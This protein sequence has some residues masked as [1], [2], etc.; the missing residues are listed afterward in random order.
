MKKSE[1]LIKFKSIKVWN[2]VP[3]D[4]RTYCIELF[5]RIYE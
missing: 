1:M 4:I 5:K 3:A 2:K